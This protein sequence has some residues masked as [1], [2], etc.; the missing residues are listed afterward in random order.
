MD[1]VAQLTKFH[2]QLRRLRELMVDNSGLVLFP[3][4]TK[5]IEQLRTELLRSYYRLED[6]LLH[7]IGK[8]TFTIENIIWGDKTY[9]LF[10]YA[11]G[12][13]G[14]ERIQALRK[15]IEV[16]NKA[17]GKMQRRQ[18]KEQPAGFNRP[19]EAKEGPKLSWDS[20]ICHASEDKNRFVRPLATKLRSKGL[21]IWYD[22]FT[23][24]VGDSLRQ[25]IENGLSKSR[26]GI[27]ILSPNFFAKKWPQDEL[28][29]LAAKERNGKKVILPVWLDVDHNYIVDYAPMLAD[30]LAARASDGMAKV[31]TD[32]LAVIKP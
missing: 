7:L 27:L 4:H 26:Y 5:E 15:C 32:L 20:F 2:D 8:Q 25:S 12:R 1:T 6:D 30:R 22:E 23:L 10:P 16:V 11:L 31:V 9:D 21:N 24:K 3:I 14:D 17:I 13:D 28:S 19:R 18:D 29:G